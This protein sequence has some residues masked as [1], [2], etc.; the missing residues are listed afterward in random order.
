[1]PGSAGVIFTAA[2]QE[3][4]YIKTRERETRIYIKRGNGMSERKSRRGTGLLF[5]IIVVILL[6]IIGF[7]LYKIITIG[8][9][10]MEGRETYTEIAEEAGTAEDAKAEKDDVKVEFDK[11]R[12]KYPDVKAWIY[13]K[14][15]IINYPV[16]QGRDNEWYLHRTLDGLWNGAGTLFIDKNNAK[17]FKDFLTII[18][19]HHMR[20]G[21]MFGSLVKYR[22][23]DYY[24]KHKTL[25]LY[26]PKQN[27]DLEVIGVCTIPADSGMYKFDFASDEEKANYIKWIEQ[28]TETECDVHAG[29]DDRL[30]M[31]STCTYE[32]D[33]ARLVVFCRIVPDQE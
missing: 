24:Q 12:K 33:D 8:H 2:Y 26:T 16:A 7:S 30:V 31:L 14:G 6:C 9:G 18:Y 10:Y 27:Y 13:S 23:D 17:P 32:F 11:L 15:T 5:K 22:D 1:M 3:R 25:R 21:S 4:Q 29:I 20:D 28:T 19:G